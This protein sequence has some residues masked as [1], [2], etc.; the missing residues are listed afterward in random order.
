[1]TKKW[2]SEGDGDGLS[3]GD[4]KAWIHQIHREMC[5]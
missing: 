5:M 1:M 4:L 3:L 2:G